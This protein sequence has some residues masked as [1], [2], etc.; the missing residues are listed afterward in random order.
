[1]VKLSR[2]PMSVTPEIWPTTNGGAPLDPAIETRVDELLKSMTI[3]EMVGQTIQA[4]IASV[5][6]DE[7][8]EYGLGS[9]LNGGNSAPNNNVRA[10]AAEWLTLADEFHGASTDTSGDRKGIPVLWGTDAVHGHNNVIGATLFPHNIGLGATRNIDLMRQIGR[11]TAREVSVTG[12]DWTFAPTLAVVRDDCWGRTYEGYSEDPT[13]VK[14][15]STAVVQGLQGE[16]DTPTFLG[17]EQV[18][19]TAKHFLGDGGTVNGIDRGD[20]QDSEEA[21]RDRHGAGYPPAIEAGVQT[22]MASFSSWNGEQMHG[23]KGLLTNVLKERM[24]FNGFVVGDWDGH[25]KVPGCS[26]SSCPAAYN[27]GLDMF[28]APESWKSLYENTVEQVKSGDIPRRR[29]EDAVRRILRVK[30]RLGLFEKPAPSQRSLAG[31]YTLL[32]APEHLAVARQAVRESLVLLKNHDNLLPLKAN[33]RVLVA[34]D[35]ADNIGKQ[36]GGWTLSWQGTGNSNSS[37]PN[38]ESIWDGI[39]AA[40]EAGGGEAELSVDGTYEEVPDVAIVVFGEDPY[41]EFKGDIDHLEFTSDLGLELLKR[42]Q[43]ADITT[44]AVFLTGRPMWVNPELNASDAF[45]VAWLPGSQGGGV[46]DVLVRQPNGAIHYDFKG[47]LSFSWP[48]TAV[49]TVNRGDA[50]YDPLFSYGYGLTYVDRSEVGLLSEDAK[51]DE[52]VANTELFVFGE[53][54]RPWVLQGSSDGQ[55]IVAVDARTQVGNALTIRSVDRNAQEDARRFTWNGNQSAAVDI[56][57]PG[58]DYSQLENTAIAIQFR[59]NTLPKEPVSLFL[60]SG[61]ERIAMDVT[62]L[63]AAAEPG[64]WTQT[65][66]SLDCFAEAGTDLEEVTTVFGLETSGEFS[67]SVS[68]IQLVADEGQAICPDSV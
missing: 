45:V 40:V 26:N 48:R 56:T 21:L 57:G 13:I 60:T 42:F 7:V 24:G 29:L 9:V 20:N 35:G 36:N 12:M 31:N 19:A 59:V 22:V 65:D 52:L 39:R 32:G 27:A 58:A 23:H 41:A 37:F 63:F 6:P 51:L 62:S 61:G 68:D 38:G 14:N 3:E 11:I 33:Q 28:M 18:I 43:A 67:I 66:I 25:G 46:A 55:S 17:D 49:Q 8:R 53:A 54:V 50:N 34:G 15:Y 16:L 5:T 10:S 1:M 44:V 64:V 2:T 30:L 47:T 4:D